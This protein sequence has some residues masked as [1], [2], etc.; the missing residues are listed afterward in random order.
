MQIQLDQQGNSTV[1]IIRSDEVVIKEVQ[2]ALDL[3]AT[4]RYEADCDKLL[5]HKSGLAEDFFELKT[6]LAGE[7][8]QKYVNYGFKLAIVGDFS[9]YDSKSLRDFIYECNHGKQFFFMSSEQEALE[10]L[11]AI[12]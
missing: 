3:M 2:D 10:A 7:I 1:A 12:R 5:L 4:V 6:K 9:V 8:L 11:H